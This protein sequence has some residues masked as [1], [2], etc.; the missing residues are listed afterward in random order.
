MVDVHT[1]LGIRDDSDCLSCEWKNNSTKYHTLLFTNRPLPS[2]L[3]PH[4]TLNANRQHA[5]TSRA[6]RLPRTKQYH[7]YYPSYERVDEWCGYSSESGKPPKGLKVTSPAPGTEQ[8][9]TYFLSVPYKCGVPTMI[10]MTISHW[11]VSEMIVFGQS[12]FWTRYVRNS[13]PRQNMDFQ[14][15]YVPAMAHAVPV[16]GAICL[17]I[18]MVC[19]LM[20]FP[21]GIPLAGCCS[22]SIAAACQ[23][24]SPR[25]LF[26]QELAQKKLKW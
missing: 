13:A 6:L 5:P 4:S 24:L 3:R 26:S 7:E 10:A 1:L 12:E 23:P 21:G 14:Y 18:V 2:K 15:G 11:L 17:I 9:S 22:A 19:L 20:K 16:N 8:R 25:E